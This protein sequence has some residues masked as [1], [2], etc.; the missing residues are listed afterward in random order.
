[1]LRYTAWRLLQIA[2]TFFLYITTVFFLFQ[3]MPGEY[4]DMFISN[5]KVP[6]EARYLLAERL[7]LTGSLGDQYLNYIRNIFTGNLGVSFGFYPRTVWDIIAERLPRTA[8]LFFT[9]TLT[10]FAL[11]Y[12]LGRYIAWRRGRVADYGVT[13]VGVLFYTIFTPLLAIILLFVFANVLGWFKVGGFLTPRLWR[14]APFS[15]QSIFIYLIATVVGLVGWGVLARLATRRIGHPRPRQLAA[16][17]LTAVGI[18]AAVVGWWS[19]GIGEYA[20]DIVW[21]LILPMLELTLISFGGTMLLMRDSM[22]EVVREDYVTTAKAKGLP[23]KV[24]RDKHA[25]RTALM[26]VVTSFTLSIGFILSGGIITETMFSW[27]GMGLTYFT[28][29]LANDYPLAMGCLVFTGVLALVAHLV[30]DLL[31]AFLDPRI[32]Y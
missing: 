16:T 28:A 29:M 24:V 31:Y 17:A 19:S 3:A 2:I 30:A 18:A 1:M 23:D 4:T 9:A 21:H 6:P 7:G 14:F 20:W 13:V 11:G 10:A 5:Y 8:I 32:T 12:P 15:A 26:P 22:L 27:E 25:A